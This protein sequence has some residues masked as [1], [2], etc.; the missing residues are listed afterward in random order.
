MCY[1]IRFARLCVGQVCVQV[2]AQAIEGLLEEIWKIMVVSFDEFIHDVVAP[3]GGPQ[4]FGPSYLI[5]WDAGRGSDGECV[6]HF[7]CVR[8]EVAHVIEL[9]CEDLV[10]SPDSAGCCFPVMGS[11]CVDDIDRH[12]VLE[13]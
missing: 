3:D 13:T 6:L 12:H 9:F 8:F 1:R 11:H 4:E 10:K 7:C 2:V 5:H